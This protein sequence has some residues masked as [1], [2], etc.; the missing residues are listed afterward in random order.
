MYCINGVFARAQCVSSDQSSHA[1]G[2]AERHAS[3]AEFADALFVASD[4]LSFFVFFLEDF[5]FD[6]DLLFPMLAA[7]KFL[8][9]TAGFGLVQRSF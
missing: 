7:L 3:F 1:H 9:T 4:F 8:Y 2:H 6:L 5:F